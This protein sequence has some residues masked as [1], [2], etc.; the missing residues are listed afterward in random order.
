MTG[1]SLPP[2]ADS[3]LR[4][5]Q[6]FTTKFP[7]MDIRKI[8]ELQR[9]DPQCKT[10]YEKCKASDSL[11][12]KKNDSHKFLIRQGVLLHMNADQEDNHVQ[13]YIPAHMVLDT[14]HFS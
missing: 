11:E 9:Q 5:L 2:I 10:A 1:G 4:F 6:Y 7:Q 12:W 3:P 14:L 8:I 13:L